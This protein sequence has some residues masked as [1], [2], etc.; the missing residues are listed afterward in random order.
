[1]SERRFGCESEPGYDGFCH[2]LASAFMPPSESL[3]QGR[4]G[5]GC[6]TVRVRTQGSAGQTGPKCFVVLAHR[7]S[8]GIVE[9][10]PV[11]KSGIWR[12][13][14]TDIPEWA[15]PGRTTAQIAACMAIQ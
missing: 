10:T 3:D 4:Q 7:R 14:G 6:C 1:M 8:A 13:K 15:E 12:H 2:T 5:A 11:P 9:G